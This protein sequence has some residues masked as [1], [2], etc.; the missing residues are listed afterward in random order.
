MRTQRK[1]DAE[2]DTVH[3]AAAEWFV[4]LQTR[5][6]SLEETLEWQRWVAES[7]EHASAFQRI[8]DTWRTFQVMEKPA[9]LSPQALA[10]DEYDGSMAVSEWETKNRMLDA[11]TPALPRTRGRERK[12]MA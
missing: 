11:P 3:G 5:E 8:E 9:L 2:R 10:E 12:G 1:T 6:M 4:R 7:E